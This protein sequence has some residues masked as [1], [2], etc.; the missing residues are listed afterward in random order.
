[1]LDQISPASF[2]HPPY[3]INGVHFAF[4][5]V[6]LSVAFADTP[7]LDRSF[8]LLG[9]IFGSTLGVVGLLFG[10]IVADRLGV[11]QLADPSDH[12]A[13]LTVGLIALWAWLNRETRG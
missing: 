6:L 3:W 9:A 5:V 7:R 8:A 2:F 4:G 12:I 10:S 13:H 1:M 11:P